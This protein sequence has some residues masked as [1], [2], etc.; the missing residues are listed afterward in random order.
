LT[1]TGARVQQGSEAS[2]ETPNKRSTLGD[3]ALGGA[4]IEDGRYLAGVRT[5]GFAKFSSNFLQNFLR[6]K[7]W[8]DFAGGFLLGGLVRWYLG[9]CALTERKGTGE[10]EKA[11]GSSVHAAGSCFRSS[12]V[13]RPSA[14]AFSAHFRA[15][16][17]NALRCA[18]LQ[19][20][21]GVPPVRRA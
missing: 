6:P 13:M 1:E 20:F 19:N 5:G 17:W 9:H 18:G 15:A 2:A 11:A 8:R 3:P 16:V 4:G 10:T 7:F 12:R 21:F 14:T